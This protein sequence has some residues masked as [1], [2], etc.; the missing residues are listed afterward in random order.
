MMRE[1]ENRRRNV[2]VGCK[3]KIY[4]IKLHLIFNF[5]KLRFLDAGSGCEFWAMVANQDK[6]FLP[7]RPVKPIVEIQ[8]LLVDD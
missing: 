8:S 1:L 3:L 4:I 7:F 5:G 2:K 6:D